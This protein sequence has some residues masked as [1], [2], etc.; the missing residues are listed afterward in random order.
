MSVIL[1]FLLSTA[2]T[3]T[4]IV[5]VDRNLEI[6]YVYYY[7]YFNIDI[8]LIIFLYKIVGLLLLASWIKFLYALFQKATL[9]N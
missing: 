4:R 3:I 5:E 9:M 1:V 8:S 7:S 2:Q 6:H